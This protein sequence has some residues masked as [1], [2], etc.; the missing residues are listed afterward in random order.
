MIRLILIVIIQRLQHNIAI[1]SS[2]LDSSHRY[3]NLQMPPDV[4]FPDPLIHYC[5]SISHQHNGAYDVY[6]VHDEIH[7]TYI[8]VYMQLVKSLIHLILRILD[9]FFINPLLIER[10]H[11]L[12]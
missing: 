2:G 4:I 7:T 8:H 10:L 9:I 11:T 5:L 12:P 1:Q 3:D 6:D